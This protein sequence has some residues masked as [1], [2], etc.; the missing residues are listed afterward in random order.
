MRT[1][2]SAVAV[3]VSDSSLTVNWTNLVP[4]VGSVALLR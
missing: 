4:G 2:I 1:D 3:A